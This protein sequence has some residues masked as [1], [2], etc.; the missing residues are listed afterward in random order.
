M[1]KTSKSP[2][3]ETSYAQRPPRTRAAARSKKALP[4]SE[5]RRVLRNALRWVEGQKRQHRGFELTK[6]TAFARVSA[7]V[8][9]GT[10]N[11]VAYYLQGA[12]RRTG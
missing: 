10:L 8:S 5:A 1:P 7:A 3:S 9:R 6:S 11:A 12:M 2:K 4:E